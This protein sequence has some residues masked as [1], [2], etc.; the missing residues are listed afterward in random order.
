MQPLSSLEASALSYKKIQLD[1][2]TFRA[3]TSLLDIMEFS[4]DFRQHLH[5]SGLFLREVFQTADGTSSAETKVKWVGIRSHVCA[6]W[7]LQMDDVQSQNKHRTTWRH[8]RK[9]VNTIQ[10]Q[11]GRNLKA[12]LQIRRL[13][14]NIQ[15]MKAWKAVRAER[16][17]M[18]QEEWAQTNLVRSLWRAPKMRSPK[19]THKKVDAT[20]LS[21]RACKL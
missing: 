5:K 19:R 12:P 7:H 11:L 10:L 15:R 16:H 1:V 13:S 21:L 8:Q 4:W 3:S 18:S 2:P 20:K 14:W 17:Q 9:Q 6:S